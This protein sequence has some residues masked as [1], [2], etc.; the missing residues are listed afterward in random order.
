MY[1]QEWEQEYP[2]QGTYT[3][4]SIIGVFP[5]PTPYEVRG[6]DYHTGMR[7]NLDPVNLTTS[8]SPTDTMIG[9]E[10]L[11]LARLEVINHTTTPISLNLALMVS[12]DAIETPG[13]AVETKE[14]GWRLSNE[15]MA[16]VGMT[17]PLVEAP[18]GVPTSFEVP[19]LAPDGTPQRM[20][21]MLFPIDPDVDEDP[22]F[23]T[24]DTESLDPPCETSPGM[25][26]LP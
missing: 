9:G 1:F 11:Y 20:T 22:L 7:I 3:Y 23:V 16:A 6:T 19:I 15:S 12:I 18:V 5:S 24:W 14:F 8:I 21:T 17:M 2:D 25:V 26:I 4:P 13:G 10:R